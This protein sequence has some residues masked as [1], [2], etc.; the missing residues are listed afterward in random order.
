MKNYNYYSGVTLGI[1]LTLLILVAVIGTYRGTQVY[2]EP[3]NEPTPTTE[4]PTT[5]YDP[6]YIIL[7]DE[8]NVI[9]VDTMNEIYQDE[10]LVNEIIE[11]AVEEHPEIRVETTHEFLGEFKLTF[12]CSCEN[13]CGIGGGHTTA[14]GTTPHINQTVAVDTDVIPFGTRLLI[15]GAE[16]IAEDRGGAIKQNR[17]DIYVESHEKALEMGV[18]YADVYIVKEI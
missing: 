7:I 13:C 3:I 10:I 17:I 8:D 1:V 4:S 2:V 15:N 6:P 16:Y 9:D 5:I 14:S 11:I 18:Q 12:Y